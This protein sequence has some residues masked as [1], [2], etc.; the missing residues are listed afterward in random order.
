MKR[1]QKVFENKGE[2]KMLI[3]F[4]SEAPAVLREGVGAT[5]C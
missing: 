4:K 2:D 3:E 1:T 5:P